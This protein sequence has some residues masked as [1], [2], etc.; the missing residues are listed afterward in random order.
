MKKEFRHKAHPVKVDVQ[1]VKVDKTTN[2]LIYGIIFALTFWLYGNTLFNGYALDDAIVIT[3]NEFTKK[4][5]DGIKDVLTTEGF[6]G[7]FGTKKNLVAGGRYRPLS[8]V[9]FAVEYSMFK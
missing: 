1:K 4:W 6:T 9:T 8:L 2:Y 7:F 5:I 3:Q